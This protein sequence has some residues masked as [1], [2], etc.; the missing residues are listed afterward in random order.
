MSI[1]FNFA[2]TLVSSPAWFSTMVYSTPTEVQVQVTDTN[3]EDLFN[4]VCPTL[5]T[6]IV[7]Y[8]QPEEDK[9]VFTI[10]PISNEYMGDYSV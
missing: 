3:E 5:P 1:I 6:D 10:N 4:L 7:S 2:P 9:F 8:S